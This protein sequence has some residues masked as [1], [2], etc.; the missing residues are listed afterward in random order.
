MSRVAII[1]GSG[2]ARLGEMTVRHRKLQRTP[3]GEPS[4]PF[5]HVDMGGQPAVLLA[6]HGF[7]HTIP[8]HRVNYRANI[9]AL[10]ELGVDHVVAIATVGGITAKFGTGVLALPH[11]LIDYT[12]SRSNTFFD[13]EGGPLLHTDFTEPYCEPLRQQLLDA[14]RQAQVS[15][16]PQAVYAATQGPRFETAAEI[17]RLERDGADVVGMT[18]M[19]EA[20]LARELKLCYASIAV[21][22]NPAAGRSV[23]PISMNEIDSALSDG[24]ARVRCLLESALGLLGAEE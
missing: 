23:G 11:Q 1:G 21:V 15:L 20:V 16:V 8:P 6:R 5:V 13:G 4:G 18:G 24:M 22:V 2:V 7:G 10:R 12:H 17:N 3:Y 14:A 19:P 9:W